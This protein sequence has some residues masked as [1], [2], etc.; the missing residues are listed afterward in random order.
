[1]ELLEAVDMSE[2]CKILPKTNTNE[3]VEK[4]QEIAK[5][6][7]EEKVIPNSVSRFEDDS[8]KERR[9]PPKGDPLNQIFILPIV[10]F[11]VAGV[12]ILLNILTGHNYLLV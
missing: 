6:K 4:K 1:M 2:K 5:E 10:I 9:T 3:Q 7:I 8:A 12:V 11:G